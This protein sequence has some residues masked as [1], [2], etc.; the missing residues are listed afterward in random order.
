[1]VS[2]TML[3]GFAALLVSCAADSEETSG[4]GTMSVP[5]RITTSG[6]S[7]TFDENDQVS[8]YAWVNN[9]NGM[10]GGAQYDAWLTEVKMKYQG[11][12]WK[13]ISSHPLYW[14]DQTT[15]HIFLAVSPIRGVSD[16][17][18]DEF[19]VTDDVAAADLRA[20]R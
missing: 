2:L 16:A 13:N 8:I 7:T 12:E 14:K 1:M 18:N 5:L 10:T 17:L 9:G 20:A 3:T 15:E 11:G 6:S 4:A 19:T